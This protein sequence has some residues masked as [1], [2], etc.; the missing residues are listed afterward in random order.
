VTEPQFQ[1]T[2]QCAVVPRART[3]PQFLR[4]AT[5]TQKNSFHGECVC[6]RTTW[7]C[8]SCGSAWSESSRLKQVAKPTGTAHCIIAVN[9]CGAGAL[10]CA[11]SNIALYGVFNVSA[12]GQLSAPYGRSVCRGVLRMLLRRT[13]DPHG[14][15]AL[16]ESENAMGSWCDLGK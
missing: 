6:Q 15:L 11:G 8:Y 14:K 13:G 7:S 1:N 10:G 16:R 12:C 5:M 4:K 3:T 2:S 9:G